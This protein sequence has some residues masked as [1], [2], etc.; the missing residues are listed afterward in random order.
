MNN[1]PT[2][3]IGDVPVGH[4]IIPAER[5]AHNVLCCGWRQHI[6][7]HHEDGTTTYSPCASTGEYRESSDTPVIWVRPERISKIPEWEAAVAAGLAKPG[8]PYE[9]LNPNTIFAPERTRP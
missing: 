2:I 3:H 8:R 1:P 9:N 7:A 6:D 5:N 4:I